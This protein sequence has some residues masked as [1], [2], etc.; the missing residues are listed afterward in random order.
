MAGTI[1]R[2]SSSSVLSCCGPS[3]LLPY[4]CVFLTQDSH[5]S[6][7]FTV[8]A[9]LTETQFCNVCYCCSPQQSILREVWGF[10]RVLPMITLVITFFFFYV[11]SCLQFFPFSWQAWGSFGALLLWATFHTFPWSIYVM[12]VCSTNIICSFITTYL[13]AKAVC[14]GV[15]TT[16]TEYP[17]K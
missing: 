13:E 1:L 17:R 10:W 9:E 11:V 3:K 14:V 5:L 15:I 7:S 6:L 16:V 8:C 12:W 4:L 2:S